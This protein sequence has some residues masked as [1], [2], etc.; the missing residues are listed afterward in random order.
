VWVLL[1]LAE[2]VVLLL[3]VEL[4]LG[5]HEILVLEHAEDELLGGDLDLEELARL[6]GGGLASYGH[7]AIHDHFGLGVVGDV[8]ELGVMGEDSR[9]QLDGASGCQLRQA[10]A[11]S[12]VGSRW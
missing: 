6:P 2:L 7:G 1:R 5:L 9:W 3:L 11:R 4:G 10:E 12:G 8:G